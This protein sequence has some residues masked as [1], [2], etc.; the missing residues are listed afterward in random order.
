MV[1][2][3][4]TF[5][6]ITIGKRTDGDISILM[7]QLDTGLVLLEFFS[8]FMDVFY[9]RSYMISTLRVEYGEL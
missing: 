3:Q 7:S 9:G 5:T 1:C 2:K 8:L 4:D 6:R